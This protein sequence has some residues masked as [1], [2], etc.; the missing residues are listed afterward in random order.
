MKVDN[1]SSTTG[2]NPANENSDD[3]FTPTDDQE[4][5]CHGCIIQPRFDFLLPYLFPAQRPAT[6]FDC[7][8]ILPS[9]KSASLVPALAGWTC[10]C[11][12]FNDISAEKCFICEK[13]KPVETVSGGSKRKNDQLCT[14]TA[15]NRASVA[16]S[17]WTN[18]SLVPQPLQFDIFAPSCWWKSLCRCENCL[19]LYSSRDC[20]WIIEERDEENDP[21]LQQSADAKEATEI[22]N[23]SA[24]S[25]N[26][27]F[28]NS[29]S[30]SVSSRSRA[31]LKVLSNQLSNGPSAHSLTAAST[32]LSAVLDA[33]FSK[34]PRDR[35][36]AGVEKLRGYL[37]SVA[38]Q[39]QKFAEETQGK[40]ITQEIMQEFVRV[41]KEEQEDEENPVKTARQE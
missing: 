18:V 20:Q 32:E 13:S 28:T 31:V 2:T 34:L 15:P 4:L 26:N 24:A 29:N 27:N 17:R 1:S 33:E 22:P 16:C 30:N 37:G 40:A 8:Q 25:S 39:A 38:R 19:N 35:V 6:N 41:A 11:Q 3:Y 14:E 9:P 12:Y 23:N 7:P 21:Q 5:I 36:L 10:S